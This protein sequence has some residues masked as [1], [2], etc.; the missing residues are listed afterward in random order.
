V[1]VFAILWQLIAADRP[2]SPSASST[3]TT[4]SS[5]STAVV[6][7]SDVNDAATSGDKKSAAAVSPGVDWQVFRT[8]PVI[9]VIVA[10][11]AS[12]N[13]SNT[14]QQWGPTYFSDV[15][16]TSPTAA[17]QYMALA[18]MHTPTLPNH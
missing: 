11:I 7:D 12:N 4:S 16:G 10:Q 15:L 13:Q 3:G 6:S 17:G 8:A 18:G 1:A 5:S 9:A 2:S 14:L